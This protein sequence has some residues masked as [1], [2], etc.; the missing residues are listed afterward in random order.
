MNW[1]LQ[2]LLA[3]VWVALARSLPIEDPNDQVELIDVQNTNQRDPSIVSIGDGNRGTD[4]DPTVIVIRTSGSNNQRRRQPFI[5]DV[6]PF[7]DLIGGGAGGSFLDFIVG[8]GAGGGSREDDDGGPQV[9]FDKSIPDIDIFDAGQE[10]SAG[11]PFTTL[12]DIGP[13]SQDGRRC[14][15]LC[16]VM[17]AFEEKIREKQANRENEVVANEDEGPEATYEEKVLDDGTVIKI[18][19]TSYSGSS[20][21]GTSFITSFSTSVSSFGGDSPLDPEDQGPE[22]EAEQGAA[23]AEVFTDEGRFDEEPIKQRE[24]MDTSAVNADNLKR[25]RR[26]QAV[27]GSPQQVTVQQQID[28]FNQQ[29]EDLSFLNQVL[30]SPF[31]QSPVFYFRRPTAAPKAVPVA[32]V[33]TQPS[34][35]GDTRVND[36]LLQTARRG[37]L[38]RLEPDAEF[39]SSDELRRLQDEDRAR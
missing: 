29:T 23:D 7:L 37:G 34:Y 3:C 9:I 22:E 6:S 25:R 27:S 39:I 31:Q 14:G 28:P 1:T 12:F 18:N 2:Y 5:G 35:A 33:D 13:G 36:L 10:E 11:F 17:K 30:T 16:T 24:E 26:R 21:D 32:A 19:R 38:V 15:F 8:G 4:F 20:E